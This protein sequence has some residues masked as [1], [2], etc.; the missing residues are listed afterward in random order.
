MGGAL[1]LF[2]TNKDNLPDFPVSKKI[3]PKNNQFVFFK[4][5]KKSFHQVAE[6]Q[7]F[8][9]PR[10][11]INGWFHGFADNID[12]KE[13]QLKFMSSTPF[14]EQPS[15]SDVELEQFISDEYLK[16]KIKHSIQQQIEE[17]SETA[18]AEFLA[19]SFYDAILEDLESGNFKWTQKSPAN[20]HHYEFLDPETLG[21]SP[22]L[23][24]ITMCKSAAFFEL[25]KDYTELELVQ[26]NCELQRFSGG[27]YT[28]IG[29]PSSFED[30]SL[31]LVMHFGENERAGII[32]YLN[33][34]AEN[35][36]NESE[37]ADEIQDEESVLLTI[38]PQKNVLNLVYRSEGTTKFTKYCYK[39]S[40][41]SKEFT[42]VLNCSYKE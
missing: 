11:T 20:Q 41:S 27:N 31:D 30:C 14:Y 28:L 36:D 19:P 34:E 10:L 6:V 5:C 29:D 16:P 24:F 17:N 4:V 37:P 13:D 7:S 39:S 9:Y 40:P 33:P 21:D 26:V 22:I 12:F 23:E 15:S 38:Y 2:S 42:Y 18:L 25:L 32:T 8:D 3:F 1:D 35:E